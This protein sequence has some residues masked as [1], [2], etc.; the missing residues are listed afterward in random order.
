MSA[1]YDE[2]PSNTDFTRLSQKHFETSL[3][4]FLENDKSYLITINKVYYFTFRVKKKVLKQ[5]L[6]TNNLYLANI[7]KLKIIKMIKNDY[8]LK[9]T[10]I[11]SHLTLDISVDKGDNPEAVKAFEEKMKKELSE[12]LANNKVSKAEVVNTAKMTIR[13]AIE[14]YMN[15]LKSHEKDTSLSTLKN[16]KSAFTYLELFID[17][18]EYISKLTLNFWDDLKTNLIHTPRDYLVSPLLKEQDLSLLI[19]NNKKLMKE[20]KDKLIDASNDSSK[21]AV[22]NSHYD[23]LI[24]PPLSNVTI[25]N[26]FRYFKSFM[27]YLV[28]KEY[29]KNTLNY[30]PLKE[31]EP[32][33]VE[34]KF[35]ELKE[36]FKFEIARK[37]ASEKYSDLEYQNVYKFGFLSGMRCQTNC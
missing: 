1:T 25:N 15:D 4:H 10:K 2:N 19:R 28:D 23:K 30:K 37:I 18:D 31:E 6:S 33:K 32:D 26:H 12:L 13:E 35:K 8:G 16:N 24:I 21:I 36:L 5:T 17:F 29:M 34:F 20:K 7:T 11:N 9:M 27:T 3:K 14:E 22:V